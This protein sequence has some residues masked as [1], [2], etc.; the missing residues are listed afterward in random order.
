MLARALSRVR[1]GA[2]AAAAAE[3]GTPEPQQPPAEAEPPEMPMSPGGRKTQL[4]RDI[5]TRYRIRTKAGA[6]S[7]ASVFA[8][9]D[10]KDGGLVALKCVTDIFEN[11]HAAKRA[12]REAS[13]LRQCDHPNVVKCKAVLRPP[14]PDRFS[15]LWMV[16]EHCDWDLRTVLRMNIVSWTLPHVEHIMHQVLSGLDYLHQHGIVHRD[17][18]PANVL[19]NKD[20]E[21]KICDFGLA[22]QILGDSSD[23][24]EL[25]PTRSLEL[26]GGGA[27]RGLARTLS[28][29]VVTRYYRAPELLLGTAV[30]GSAI[31]IWS[32]GCILAE[33]LHSLSKEDKHDCI[34]FRGESE[35]LPD[36][37][38]ALR[39]ELKEPR[40]MLRLQLDVL[41]LPTPAQIDAVSPHLSM[42]DAFCEFCAEQEGSWA[43]EEQ[44]E[45]AQARQRTE[46]LRQRFPAAPAAAVE[47]L[48]ALLQWNPRLRPQA[49]DCLRDSEDDD[50]APFA[51][52]LPASGKAAEGKAKGLA[53]FSFAFE[54]ARQDKAS[55]R[56]LILEQTL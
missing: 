26:S 32:V 42:R 51:D 1:R 46:R 19:I 8:A 35:S 56:K 37:G 27:S 47:L 5:H 53:D 24:E 43:A 30:Y 10:T 23:E 48:S 11:S 39:E 14:N 21:A 33:L 4:P 9:E 7:H 38:D 17:L 25:S 29:Q 52:L 55:L 20:C 28:R 6:G 16:L 40:S 3:E 50:G 34:L 54:Q 18:K 44:D 41:G 12:L 36:T 2:A 13:I 31:D 22:R 49:S 15:K 45:E